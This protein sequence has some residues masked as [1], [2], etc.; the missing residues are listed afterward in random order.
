VS[1]FAIEIVPK[2]EPLTDLDRR[3]VLEP[4]KIL[5][6]LSV[7]GGRDGPRSGL[8]LSLALLA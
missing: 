2:G 4:Q 1:L 8:H 5:N 7:G 6:A 3:E